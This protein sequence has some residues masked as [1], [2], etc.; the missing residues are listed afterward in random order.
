VAC[1]NE[2]EAV[3]IGIPLRANWIDEQRC[4]L[5]E[6]HEHAMG[7][8][9]AVEWL[10]EHFGGDVFLGN[11]CALNGV[12]ERDAVRR[13]RATCP[14]ARRFGYRRGNF[15]ISSVASHPQQLARLRT[16]RHQ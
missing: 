3:A 16:A 15:S 13:E 6:S 9:G 10:R 2:A 12:Y 5:F 7:S 14:D 11:R 1:G 8:T 4:L